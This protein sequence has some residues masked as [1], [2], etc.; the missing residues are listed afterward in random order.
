L[1]GR[2]SDSGSDRGQIT[3][4]SALESTGVEIE[5]VFNPLRNWRIS[6]SAA[7][8]EAVRT[9]IAP[10]LF[11]FLFSP[12]DGLMTLV[13][14]SDGTPTAAGRLLGAPTGSNSLLTYLNG[15]VINNGLITTFAQEGTKTDELRKWSFR[16]VTNYQFGSE[17][18]DGKLKGF[19]V[20]GAIRWSDK[21]LLGYGGTTIVSGGQTLVVSDVSRPYFGPRE[22]IVDLSVG[23]RRKLTNRMNWSIQL[24]VKNVGVGE[25]LRPLGVWPDGRVV[26]WTIK[27]PMKW[28]LSNS[29]TF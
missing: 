12:T 28:T 27:E 5:M 1:Y 3:A 21:Q 4:V 11:N 8:A 9:N 24:F 7:S 15:N 26:N 23:Y 22:T 29:F 25:E 19:N 6:A 13:Q 18:F 10:E 2:Y 16:A 14:N 17:L 20:G